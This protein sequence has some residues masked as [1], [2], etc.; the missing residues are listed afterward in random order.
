MTASTDISRPLVLCPEGRSDDFFG[1][2]EHLMQDTL[3]DWPIRSVVWIFCVYTG[4]T[5]AWLC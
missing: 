1:W 3:V 4:L 2:I 5:Y